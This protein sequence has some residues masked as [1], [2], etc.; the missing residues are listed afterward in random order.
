MQKTILILLFITFS[1]SSFSQSI[2]DLDFLIGTWKVVETILPGTEKAYQEIGTRTCSYYLNGSFIK[3]ESE[4]VIQKNG[5]KRYYSYIINYDKKE[6]CFR[7]TNFAN[8]FPLHGQFK[9]FLDK[10]N[11]RIIAIT[12]K[13]VIEDRFFRAT[14]SY[15]NKDKL[16][17]NG[18]ASV[19]K[20]DK[21]WK[22]IFNDVATR[23][24]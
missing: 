3:C 14:I 21:D 19:F 13:N 8:D 20:K 4:T 6:N 10:E 23:V 11:K 5:R 17:W 16:V 9:W 22:Q 2:K 7:A 15:A 24:K 12:P 1:S 18:W